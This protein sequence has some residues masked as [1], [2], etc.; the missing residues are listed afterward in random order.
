[1]CM[2]AFFSHG[3]LPAQKQV[4]EENKKMTC[5]V[6]VTY[7]RKE[8][9]ARNVQMLLRQIYPIDR[10]IIVDNHSTDGTYDLLLEKGWLTGAFFYIDTQENIGG[11][12][13]FFTGMK[14]AYDL[15]ADWT[16][17]MDDDGC[18]ADEYTFQH[19]M[20]VAED[21]YQRNVQERKLFI[22]CLVQQREMLSFKLGKW[23]TVDEAVAAQKDGI[24]LNEANPFNGTVISR[25]L[26]DAI[27]F[28]NPAFFIKGD[29][30]D[31]KRRAFKAGAFVGTVVAARYNHPRPDTWEKRVLGVKVPFIVEA[32]WK[33]YYTARNFTYMYKQEK[34]YKAILFELM[35]VKVLA[36]L[37]L[38]CRKFQSVK[39]LCMGVKDGWKG[40]MGATVRP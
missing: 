27:G 21:L 24:I 14:A 2:R 18:A 3:I 20:Q 23:Y 26:V 36:I 9:L 17:L 15:G 12:G 13:G 1:M 28:P 6:V 37:S 34:Q 38:R 4:F 19:L 10:I 8:L 22:N 33:E 29:E 16:I 40:R 30:V 35:F 11:A 31:Y 25:A 5:A 32:P 7:N 39:M